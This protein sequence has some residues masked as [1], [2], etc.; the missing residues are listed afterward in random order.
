[1]KGG[2]RGEDVK[3]G[4]RKRGRKWKER[5]ERSSSGGSRGKRWRRKIAEEGRREGNWR[6]YGGGS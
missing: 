6:V 3:G 5:E 4:L 1:M 2:Q